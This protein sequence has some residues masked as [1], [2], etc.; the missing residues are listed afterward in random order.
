MR[1]VTEA[2]P[3]LELI[4]LTLAIA[5]FVTIAIATF[6]I[7]RDMGGDIAVACSVSAQDSPLRNVF[8]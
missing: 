8:N 4:G 1:E 2:K 3:G 5:T 7:A 6:V